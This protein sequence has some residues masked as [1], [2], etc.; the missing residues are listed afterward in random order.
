MCLVCVV[1]DEA[2]MRKERHGKTELLL[3][4]VQPSSRRIKQPTPRFFFSLDIFCFNQG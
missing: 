3:V 1:G 4:A 2:G